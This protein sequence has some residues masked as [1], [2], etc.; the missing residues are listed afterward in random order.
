MQAITN[1]LSVNTD[2]MLILNKKHRHDAP[3]IYTYIALT[4][5]ITNLSPST[6]PNAQNDRF[7][8]IFTTLRP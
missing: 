2:V 1:Q 7:S 4:T 3:T 6:Q 5:N 8:L